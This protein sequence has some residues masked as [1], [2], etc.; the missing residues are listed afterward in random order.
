MTNYLAWY[1]THGIQDLQ[2]AG[3]QYLGWCPFHGDQ[4]SKHKGFSVN[5]DTGTWFCFSCNEGGN[6]IT[7]CEKKGLKAK[8]APDYDP[9]YSRYSY[10][11]GIVKVKPTKKDTGKTE[12]WEGTEGRGL[13]SGMRPYNDQ[14]IDQ[15]KEL[16][17]PLWICEGEKDTLTMLE[18][19]ELA[20][21]IP[22]ATTDKV[23]D[24]VPFN[25]VKGL[26]LIIVMDNDEAG[27]KARDRIIERLPWASWAS[28]SEDE[29]KGLDVTALKERE[30]GAF[31]DILQG[32]IVEPQDPYESLSSFLFDKYDRDMQRDPEKPLGYPLTKFRSISRNVDGI[33]PGLYIVGAE[34]NVAKTA[35]LCNLFL[36]LAETNKDLTCIYYSLDDSKNVISNRLL[37]IDSD[38][39]LNMVQRKQETPKHT[40]M[41]KDAY[42]KLATL[43][44]KHRLHIRDASEINDIEALEADIR[45][46]MDRKLCVIIDALYDL[47]VGHERSIREANIYR[48][49]MLKGLVTD[50]G[51]PVVCSAELRKRTPQEKSH[52]PTLDRIM[53]TG[54]YAYKGDVVWLLYA[55]DPE[56]YN[57]MAIDDPILRFKYA[58]NK[59]SHYRGTDALQFFRTTNKLNE[60]YETKEA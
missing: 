54:K 18:A 38:I 48:A 42:A 5:P 57:N 9:H 1:G 56:E 49:K 32:Q 28:W 44:Q 46:R 43:S 41:I 31:V 30:G 11:G 53:E 25:R 19:G 16:N 40:G 12:R 58:K 23:L 35:F 14:A 8:E 27:E 29:A 36:D 52:I 22:S 33:Q 15:A 45:R 13:P 20:I 26:Q 60:W 24:A 3:R 4:G 55:E 59:L 37:S 2:K 51:I 50:Y 17:R 7:F 34:T 39:P 6:A 21:G 10:G 47:D